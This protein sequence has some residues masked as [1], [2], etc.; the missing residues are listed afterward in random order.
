MSLSNGLEKSLNS[1]NVDRTTDDYRLATYMLWYNSGKPSAEVLHRALRPDPNSGI[2]PN[3]STL[4]IWIKDS[5]IPTALETDERVADEVNQAM[6]SQRI[7]MLDRHAE[8][9]K[10]MQEMAL[11]Y[12]RENGLGS[13]RNALTALIQGV[14][15]EHNA[16]I[17]PT[18]ILAKLGTMSDSKLL[19]TFTDMLNGGQILEILPNN[20]ANENAPQSGQATRRTESDSG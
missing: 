5:F 6:V 7:E 3:V 9:A 10:E 16:R 19:E 14:E 20:D 18:D 1:A 13:S 4:R 17:I 8:I 15:M 12:L 11:A 2:K